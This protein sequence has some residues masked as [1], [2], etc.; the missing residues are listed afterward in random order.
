VIDAYLRRLAK[1]L[2]E[3]GVRGRAARRVL[4]EGRDHLTEA[5]G[6]GEAEALRRFGRVEDIAAEIAA[7]VATTRTRTAAFA[8]FGVLVVAGIGCALLLALVPAAGGWQDIAGGRL[9]I[10]SGFVGVALLVLGQVSFV[11]GCLAVL[12]AVRIRRRSY[13]SAAELGLLRRRSSVA[14][15]AGVGTLAA[16]AAYA[17]DFDAELA[18]WWI[19]LTVA[20]C[21]VSAALLVT[22]SVQVVRSAAPAAPAGGGAG[23]V[24]DDLAALDPFDLARR[25]RLPDHPWRFAGLC[26]VGVGL[27]GFVAGTYVEGDP[28]SGLVRGG[29]EGVALLLCFAVFGRTLG[30]R[31]PSR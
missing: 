17:L 29:F 24:F 3:L 4:A 12:R 6:D 27:V 28:G 30:L 14:L 10:W 9:G 5:A 25:L 31:R 13:V 19:W 15:A 26:A 23:D 1:R 22:A 20:F 21:T 16:L 2:D 8:T 7:V 18:D 11:A